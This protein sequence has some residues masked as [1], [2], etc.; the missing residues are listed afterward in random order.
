MCTAIPYSFLQ[1]VGVANDHETAAGT[2]LIDGLTE[3]EKLEH[4]KRTV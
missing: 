1:A 3:L 4:K 2:T